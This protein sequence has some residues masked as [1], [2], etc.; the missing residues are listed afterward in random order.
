MPWPNNRCSGM[1]YNVVCYILCTTKV[2]GATI[3]YRID[4]ITDQGSS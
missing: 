2:V 3:V 1:D 4:E